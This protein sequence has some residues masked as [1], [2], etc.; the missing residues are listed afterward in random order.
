MVKT[1]A[2]LKV[3]MA[4]NWVY[5]RLQGAN[6]QVACQAYSNISPMGACQGHV[7]AQAFVHKPFILL[8]CSVLG[9]V[10]EAPH[11]EY[12]GSN[13]P[14]TPLLNRHGRSAE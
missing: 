1:L 8:P 2:H 5:N 10:A 6:L 9:S 4:Y 14:D 7:R 3:R 12:T 11:A 13:D